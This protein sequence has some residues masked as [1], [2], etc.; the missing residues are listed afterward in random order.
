MGS[1]SQRH[2]REIHGSDSAG[3]THAPGSTTPAGSMAIRDSDGTT[4][5]PAVLA[6]AGE[7]DAADIARANIETDQDAAANFDYTVPSGGLSSE[8][9]AAGL[10]AVIDGGFSANLIATSDGNNVRI[11]AD[12]TAATVTIN[13]VAVA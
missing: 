12:G 10:A 7:W 1:R 11:L 2:L 3:D 4:A 8:A 9:V 13:S 5:S 6:C